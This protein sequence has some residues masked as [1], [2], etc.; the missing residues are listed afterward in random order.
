MEPLFAAIGASL[1]ILAVVSVAMIVR[2]IFPSLSPEDQASLRGY[3]RGESFRRLRARDRAISN[4]WKAH[5]HLYP[6][7][8]K[9]LLFALCLTAGVLALMTCPLWLAFAAR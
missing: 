9:R 3:W 5:V 2:D 4:A 8:R 6:R 7:S 1:L